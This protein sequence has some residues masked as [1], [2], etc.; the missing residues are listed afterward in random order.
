MF[1]NWD[2]GDVLG[3]M[4]SIVIATILSMLLHLVVL[5]GTACC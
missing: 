1:A 4:L 2:I 3:S 5:L